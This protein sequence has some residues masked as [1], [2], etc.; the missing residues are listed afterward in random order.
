MTMGHVALAA[1]DQNE[2]R[3]PDREHEDA[4]DPKVYSADF[5]LRVPSSRLGSPSGLRSPYLFHLILVPRRRF[6][7]MHRMAARRTGIRRGF[8]TR[9]LREV[10]AVISD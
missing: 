8:C 2:H 7:A 3:E 9:S 5:L 1:W 6:V 4:F 10:F